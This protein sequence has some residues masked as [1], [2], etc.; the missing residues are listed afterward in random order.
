MEA[1]LVYTTTSNSLNHNRK[2]PALSVVVNPV[3]GGV[4]MVDTLEVV[5][6]AAPPLAIESGC[7]VEIEEPAPPQARC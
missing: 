7:V 2:S 3:T 4:A 5:A 6:V 1:S